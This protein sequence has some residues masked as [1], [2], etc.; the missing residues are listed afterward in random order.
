MGKLDSLE[1]FI[2]MGQKLIITEEERRNIQLMYESTPP[3]ESV[4]VTNKNPFTNNEYSSAIRFYSGDMKD[5]DLFFKTTD[6]LVSYLKSEINKAFEGKSVKIVCSWY[7]KNTNKLETVTDNTL[8]FP[9]CE[10]SIKKEMWEGDLGTTPLKSLRWQ[11]SPTLPNDKSIYI[12]GEGIIWDSV[13][14]ITYRKCIFGDPT[15]VTSTVKSIT[16]WS[17]IPDQYFEIRKIQR[18]KTDF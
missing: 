14:E 7:E 4:L 18:S 3:D 5:G 11:V 1:V 12:E 17:K 6:T 9:K 16:D 15:K 13:F 2:F 8:I 10:L